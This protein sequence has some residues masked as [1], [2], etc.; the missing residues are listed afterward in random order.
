MLKRESGKKYDPRKID[1][2]KILLI[3]ELI[4][5]LALLPWCFCKEEQAVSFNGD[6][7]GA[8]IGSEHGEPE[9]AEGHERF[10]SG[11]FALGP[12]VYQIRVWTELTEDQ[13][14]YV[15]MKCDEAYFRSLRNDGATIFPGNNYQDFEVYVLDKLSAAY[16]Q[17]DFFGAGPGGLVRLE[18]WKTGM[19]G[20]MLYFIILVSLAL[21]NFLV[22]FRRRILAEKI[23]GKQQVVFWALAAGVLTA[24][25]PWLTDYFTGGDDVFFHLSRIAYLADA[26]KQGA[27]WPVRVEGTWLYGHGYAAPVFYGDLFLLLP[28]FLRQIGFSIM[29]SY[30]IFLL[31]VT[32]ATACVSYHSFLKCVKDEYAALFG[33]LVYLLAPYRLYNVYSRAAVGEYLAMVFLP[34]VCCGMYLLYTEDPVSGEYGKCKWYV[35]WGMSGVLQSHLISTEMAALLILA[36]CVIFCRRLFR[37]RTFC[38]LA[39]AAGLVLLI[40]AWFWAPMLYMLHCDSYCIQEITEADMQLTGL[41]VGNFFYWLPYAGTRYAVK[42]DVWVGVGAAAVLL[43]Y[44]LWRYKRKKRDTAADTFA[45]FSVLALIMSTAYF[46]WNAVMKIPGIGYVAASLQFPWRWMSPATLFLALLAAFLLRRVVEEGGMTARAALGAMAAVIAVSAVYHVDSIAFEAR[47]IY[48]YNEENMGTANVGGGEYI[49]AETQLSELHYHEPAAEEGLLWTG[50][51]KEGTNVTISLENQTDEIR[52]I[53]IPLT[54]YK[55]YGVTAADVGTELPSVSG[56]RGAHGD[57]RLTV[58]ANYRGTVQIS[59]KGFMLFRVAE[60]VSLG[61]LAVLWGIYLYRRTAARKPVGTKT[62]GFRLQ[63]RK[64]M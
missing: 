28:A 19:G 39:A 6:E 14:L 3:A 18:V 10:C 24:Y 29:N 1:S 62:G 40:N 32:A 21:L 11:R 63:R 45:A 15:Q 16:V 12:G 4:L 56:E 23:T 27:S 30:K 22:I 33:S 2:F 53:D 37:R 57:L 38:Q 25:F 48:L 7:I 17:C 42:N 51:R 60:A 50:Y 36:S 46:P 5:V 52:C 31:V 47:P 20:R 9:Q 43:F 34:L 61:G 49:L 44:A 35:V 58:P 64:G 55:G 59:Y 41:L 54:G 13:K 26:I 8:E